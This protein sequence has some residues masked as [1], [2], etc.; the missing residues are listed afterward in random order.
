MREF[1]AIMDRDLALLPVWN[2]S[3]AQAQGQ[4][5]FEQYLRETAVPR[6]V[7]D[8]FLRGPSWARFDP[9]LGYVLGN[10]CRRTGW[11]E[12]PPYP[13]SNPTAPEPPSMY[14]GKKCRINTYG[15]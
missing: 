6:D 15:D 3:S 5:T 2:V 1:R 4:V 8:R 13:R 9:E 7:I 10:T 12:A 14:A 11:T